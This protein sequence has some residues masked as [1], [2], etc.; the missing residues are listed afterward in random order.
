MTEDETILKFIESAYD[1]NVQARL[2]A[3]KKAKE[4]EKT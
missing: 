4:G 3:Y 1:I 2:E